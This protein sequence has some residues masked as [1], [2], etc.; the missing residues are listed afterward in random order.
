MAGISSKAAGKLENKFKYN[1]KEL[2]HGEFSD[3]SGLEEYDYGARLYDAQI[4]RFFVQDA[5]SEKYLSFSSYSYGA[6]NPLYFVDKNGDSLNIADLLNPGYKGNKIDIDN[7]G[8]IS[9]TGENFITSLENLTGLTLNYDEIG[10]VTYDKKAKVNRSHKTSKLARRTL[11]KI[12]N[13]KKTLRVVDGNESEN[14]NHVIN[15]QNIIHLDDAQTLSL[16]D[17]MHGPLDKE[18]LGLGMMFFH[19][20]GHTEMGGSLIDP[21]RGDYS[22]SQADILTNKIRAQMGGDYGQRESYH[23]FNDLSGEHRIM[24]FNSEM[25]QWFNDIR[26]KGIIRNSPKNAMYV[27]Y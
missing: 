12:I 3:G 27:Q 13:S 16:Q 8:S 14:G 15:H 18:T 23:F 1:G 22:I 26:L 2:Q 9:P 7:A 6:N 17:H 25:L 21:Q 19:E 11:K 20:Y 24:P 4:G 10:N 5:F